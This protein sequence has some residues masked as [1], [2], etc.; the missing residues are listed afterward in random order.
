MHHSSLHWSRS[1]YCQ[2]APEGNTQAGS[3]RTEARWQREEGAINKGRY[4]RRQDKGIQGLVGAAS[5]ECGSRMDALEFA[6]NP[7]R[8]RRK[9]GAEQYNRAGSNGVREHPNPRQEASKGKGMNNEERSKHNQRVNRLGRDTEECPA[10]KG[11]HSYTGS[12]GRTM[13]LTRLAG[14]MVLDRLTNMMKSKMIT[15]VSGCRVCTNV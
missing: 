2:A 15:K 8:E 5:N 13:V 12:N 6:Q 4:R 11:R 10:C 3:N 1:E 14:C 7:S 9:S